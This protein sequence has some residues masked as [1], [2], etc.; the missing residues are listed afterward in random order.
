MPPTPTATPRKLAW[1]D[2]RDRYDGWF[3]GVQGDKS[4]LRV[5]CPTDEEPARIVFG[6]AWEDDNL[7]PAHDVVKVSWDKGTPVSMPYKPTGWRSIM[8]VSAWPPGDNLKARWPVLMDAKT[9]FER[10]QSS[11]TVE[12]TFPDGNQDSYRV[13]GMGTAW[14][15]TCY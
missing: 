1:I 10:M 2:G 11:L 9:L 7:M 12:V 5:Y 4:T 6:T 15:K 3:I 14:N 13:G 8:P